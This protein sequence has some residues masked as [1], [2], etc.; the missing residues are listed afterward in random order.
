[1]A[2]ASRWP[3]LFSPAALISFSISRSVRYSRGRAGRL[4]VTL[5]DLGAHTTDPVFSILFP[6]ILGYT[7]TIPIRSVT[8]WAIANADEPEAMSALPLKAD[9]CG[10]NGH[11]C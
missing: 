6:L 5:T 10:A 9:M 7:V 8:V 2:E 1:M 11:V 3:H 4:T